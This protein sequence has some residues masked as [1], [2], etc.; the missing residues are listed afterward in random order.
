MREEDSER[1]FILRGTHTAENSTDL[2][3]VNINF[4]GHSALCSFAKYSVFALKMS[5]EIYQCFSLCFI[6]VESC[7]CV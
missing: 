5:S 3:R 4:F 7:V 1:L 2:I 6:S